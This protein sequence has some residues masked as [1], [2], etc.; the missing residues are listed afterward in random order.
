MKPSALP[1]FVPSAR[2]RASIER[3]ADYEARL[4]SLSMREQA[5]VNLAAEGLTDE[6]ISL[7]LGLR[8]STVNSYWARVRTKLGSLSRVEIVIDLL[9]HRFSQ[10]H[11]ASCEENERLVAELEQLRELRA[12]GAALQEDAWPLLAMLHASE[13]ILVVGVPAKVI[14]G[15][16]RAQMLFKAGTGELEGLNMREITATIAPATLHEPCGTLFG[17]GG[18]ERLTLG[19][20][21]PLY[22]CRLDGSNF[23]ALMHAERFESAK[24]PLAVIVVK[25]YLADMEPILKA[26]CRPLGFA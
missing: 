5:V 26:L 12:V 17:V 14:F 9:R 2:R 11:A 1:P 23:R 25:E 18:P 21:E 13:A 15:N 6:Q 22:A 24:G 16:R 7:A 4:H 3:D 20:D 19:I 10:A 8:V